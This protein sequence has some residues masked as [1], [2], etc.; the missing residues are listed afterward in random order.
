M[1]TSASPLWMPQEEVPP[2]TPILGLPHWGCEFIILLF[3]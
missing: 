3:F 1:E 2:V